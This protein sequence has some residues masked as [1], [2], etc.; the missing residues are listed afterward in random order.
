MKAGDRQLIWDYHNGTT[1]KSLSVEDETEGFTVRNPAVSGNTIRSSSRLEAGGCQRCRKLL[2]CVC[3]YRAWMIPM[4]TRPQYSIDNQVVTE[5]PATL[6][7]PAIA[8]LTLSY[9]YETNKTALDH[10]LAFN[11]FAFVD[12]SHACRW[13]RKTV[14]TLFASPGSRAFDSFRFRSSL[15]AGPHQPVSFTGVRPMNSWPPTHP[16]IPGNIMERPAGQNSGFWMKRRA[17]DRAV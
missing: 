6:K 16:R 10:C 13:L 7:S 5:I 3:V 11:D 12:H 14:H 2:G 15:A 4:A 9:T 1:W 8:T 17:S